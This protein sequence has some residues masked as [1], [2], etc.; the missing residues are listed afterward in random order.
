MPV[1]EKYTESHAP[2]TKEHPPQEE[3]SHG[4]DNAPA[5]FTRQ[6]MASIHES[7]EQPGTAANIFSQGGQNYRTMGRWD[8]A[9]V[10]AS[11]QVGLR[12][13]SLPKV[14]DVLVLLPGVAAILCLGIISW[15]SAYELVQFYRKHPHVVNAGRHGTRSRRDTLRNHLEHLPPRQDLLHMRMRIRHRDHLH[16]PH[17]TRYP[18][19]GPARWSLC[20]CGSHRVL[21]T[22]SA[23]PIQVRGKGR[24][25]IYGGC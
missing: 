10:L 22:L 14:L 9:L 15:Y 23:T 18:A 24:P 4:D 6:G 12:I 8:T 13:L 7:D 1:E 2:Q 25:P 21:A 16:S 3:A 5:P 11:N 19:T 17:S 20:G